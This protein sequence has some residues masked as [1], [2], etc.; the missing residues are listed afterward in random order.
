VRHQLNVREA[1]REK[2]VSRR[3]LCSSLLVAGRIF[4]DEFVE[5][6]GQNYF[7]RR[8]AELEREIH[9]LGAGWDRKS[10]VAYHDKV[11]VSEPSERPP[12]YGEHRYL[13]KD[14]ASTFLDPDYRAQEATEFAGRT[15]KRLMYHTCGHPEE[16]LPEVTE[17]LDAFERRALDEQGSVE[18]T[19][20]TLYEAGEEELAREYLTEHSSDM[21]LEGLDL[22]NALLGSIEARAE[23]LYGIEEPE[24][25]EINASGDDETVNCLVGAD[26]D[27]P[28]GDQ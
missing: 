24:G 16:F 1:A 23:L 25:N 18:N 21:A 5:E 19:A 3:V 22:G 10:G 4:E 20:A 28:P 13:T 9:D 8:G 2:L 27:L 15:F 6:A 7:E 12:E 11:R 26:P 17:A 14:S